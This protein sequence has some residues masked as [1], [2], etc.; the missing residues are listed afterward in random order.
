MKSI[1]SSNNKVTGLS[2]PPQE[3]CFSPSH[4]FSSSSRIS[5]ASSM[6]VYPFKEH[7]F[8]D[9]HQGEENQSLS[10]AESVLLA[11]K[12]SATSQMF[13]LLNNLQALRCSL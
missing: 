13:N 7:S 10:I 12:T 4:L 11:I 9:S 1:N 8:S 3:I 5:P 2:S 6:G